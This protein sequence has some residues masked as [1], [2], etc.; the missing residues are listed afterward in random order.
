MPRIFISHSVKDKKV[1]Q[2]FVNTILKLGLKIKSTN[3]YCSSLAGHGTQSNGDWLKSIKHKLKS[4]DLIIFILFKNFLKSEICIIEMGAAWMWDVDPI[5][6]RVENM[7][8]GRL[9]YLYNTK[10]IEDLRKGS[11]LDNFKESVV[12]YGMK[13]SGVAEWNGHRN[14]FLSRSKKFKKTFSTSKKTKTIKKSNS[15]SEKEMII[16]RAIYN[17]PGHSLSPTSISIRTRIPKPAVDILI[18][19]SVNS[20]FLENVGSDYQLTE[21][22]VKLLAG[23]E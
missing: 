21:K 3:I 10:T 22:A 5:L 8:L 6:L 13:G 14:E 19:T 12:K 11:N 20:G 1:V 9:K 4:Y 2:E 7:N 17:S 23:I 16:L 18:N 15:L